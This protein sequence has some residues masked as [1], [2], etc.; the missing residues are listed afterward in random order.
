M[1]TFNITLTVQ[2]DALDEEQ[3]I[4]IAKEL[5]A[6]LVDPRI[7]WKIIVDIDRVEWA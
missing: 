5:K 2:V 1:K 6:T 7:S 4:D 3:A